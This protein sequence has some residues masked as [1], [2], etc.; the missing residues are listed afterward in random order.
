MYYSAEDGEPIIRLS[1]KGED[2]GQ[3]AMD[4][5]RLINGP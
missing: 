5:A 4:L 3:R 2:I 1:P